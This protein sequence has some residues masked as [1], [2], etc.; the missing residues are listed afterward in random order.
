M[1]VQLNQNINVLSDQRDKII[2]MKDKQYIIDKNKLYTTKD[3]NKIS[4]DGVD[5]DKLSC[6]NCNDKPKFGGLGVRKKSCIYK[7]CLYI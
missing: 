7:K 6:I 3:S 1:E 2:I 5:N 4:I